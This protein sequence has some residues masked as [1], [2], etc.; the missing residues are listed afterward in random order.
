MPKTDKQTTE[1]YVLLCLK[2][3]FPYSRVSLTFLYLNPHKIIETFEFKF[4]PHKI[5]CDRKSAEWNLRIEENIL[6]PVTEQ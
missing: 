3:Y 6:L 5:N 4:I 2:D 1:N